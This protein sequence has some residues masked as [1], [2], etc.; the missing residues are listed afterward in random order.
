MLESR[1]PQ[2]TAAI[3]DRQSVKTTE[4]GGKRG[5][6]AGKSKKVES[7][8][9]KLGQSWT[10]GVLSCQTFDKKCQTLKI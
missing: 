8:V 9:I 4:A 5:L 3:I 1:L 6:D 2:P 10:K 7:A